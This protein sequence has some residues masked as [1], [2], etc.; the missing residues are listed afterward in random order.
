MARA[1]GRELGKR[2]ASPLCTKSSFLEPARLQALAQRHPRAIEQ[3]P[4]MRRRHGQFLTDLVSFEAHVLAHHECLGGLHRQPGEAFLEY[5]EELLLL[6]GA[7][8]IWPGGWRVD[9]V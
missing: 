5:G 8:R 9:P 4:A 7:V 3:H 1:C 6:E 2:G